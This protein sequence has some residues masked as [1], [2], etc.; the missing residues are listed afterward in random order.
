MGEA[1]DYRY[2]FSSYKAES[3]CRIIGTDGYGKYYKTTG[4]VSHSLGSDDVPPYALH[5]E[6]PSQRHLCG[7]TVFIPIEFSIWR[8]LGSSALF[9]LWCK[10]SNMRSCYNPHNQVHQWIICFGFKTVFSLVELFLFF[11]AVNQWYQLPQGFIVSTHIQAFFSL[12]FTRQFFFPCILTNSFIQYIWKNAAQEIYFPIALYFQ[13]ELQYK[14]TQHFELTFTNNQSPGRISSEI[15]SKIKSSSTTKEK[16][17][18]LQV[19]VLHSKLDT[20]IKL[21]F[22]SSIVYFWLYITVFPYFYI[23]FP[24]FVIACVYIVYCLGCILSAYC[25]VFKSHKALFVILVLCIKVK[26]SQVKVPIM[27]NVPI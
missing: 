2:L 5:S 21:Y 27:Q 6:A 14:W 13:A 19:D 17:T 4:P 26:S 23:V 7:P 16:N 11:S 1:N 8:F 22:D 9:L 3:T 10:A 12:L 20:D 24:S 25:R 15:F 18:P